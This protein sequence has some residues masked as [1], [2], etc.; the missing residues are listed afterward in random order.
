MVLRNLKCDVLHSLNSAAPQR[1]VLLHREVQY[2]TVVPYCSNTPGGL[3]HTST[4]KPIQICQMMYLP[5][6]TTKVVWLKEEQCLHICRVRLRR[7][8]LIPLCFLHM[9]IL[10][11]EHKMRGVGR[12]CQMPWVC[13]ESTESKFLS[14]ILGLDRTS[15]K[16]SQFCERWWIQPL[17]A[18]HRLPVFRLSEEQLEKIWP[19]LFL[20][21][22]PSERSN[23]LL[24]QC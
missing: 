1:S 11:Y 4:A 14:E 6:K 24:S 9:H 7:L 13:P 17:E 12:M 5:V 8:L 23:S 18:G 15:Q 20:E 10:V 3:W 2:G 19:W 21:V 16:Q 22:A